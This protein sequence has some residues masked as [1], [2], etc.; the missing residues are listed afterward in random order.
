[1]ASGRWGV[2]VLAA[3][4]GLAASWPAAAQWKWRDGK[5]QTQYSDL[6]PPAGVPDQD[7]LQRP[8][9]GSRRN[10]APA[11]AA[12]AASA[13]SGAPLLAP[14]ASDPELEARRKKAEQEAADKK[15]VEDP[16]VAAAKASNCARARSNLQTIESGR[17]LARTNAKGEQEYLDDAAR[18]VEAT[19]E[20]SVIN[21]QCPQ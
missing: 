9:P 6:P 21:S 10:A 5:G 8:A 2:C 19:H 13:A 12:P 20:R 17:R 1:M 3:A 4:I 14:R 16:K 11:T 18:A 7:I 15:K